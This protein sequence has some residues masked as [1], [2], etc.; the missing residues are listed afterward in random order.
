MNTKINIYMYFTL[1]YFLIRILFLIYFVIHINNVLMISMLYVCYVKKNR[2]LFINLAE[3]NINHLQQT[4]LKL[5]ILRY[6]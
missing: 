5:I 4:I 6:L 1:V 3:D 2:Y